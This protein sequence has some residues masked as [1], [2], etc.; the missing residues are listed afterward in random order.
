MD[1]LNKP[2]I[3]LSHATKDK[4]FVER[5]ASDLRKC[6]VEPWLDSEE[7]RDGRPWL[8]MIFEDGIATCDCILVYLTENSINSKMVQK[9][10]DA[11][12][13]QQLDDEGVTFLPYVSIQKIR[14]KL[15]TDIRSLHCREWNSKNYYKV[16]PSVVAEIWQSYLERTVR[17]AI[18]KERVEKQE[19]EK[20]YIELKNRTKATPFSKAQIQDFQYIYDALNLKVQYSVSA[21]IH[22]GTIS[23]RNSIESAFEYD[24]SVDFLPIL[25]GYVKSGHSNYS[26]ERFGNFLGKLSRDKFKSELPDN[27]TLHATQPQPN[28]STELLTLGLMKTSSN[29]YGNPFN[30][31]IYKFIY[32]LGYNKLLS[33]DVKMKIISKKKNT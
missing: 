6:K 30:A 26:E 25:I 22:E 12:F 31:K 1:R 23:F 24:V 19:I 15:R 11:A 4:P 7:I 9:E 27:A 29:Y 2:R 33:E 10:I 5:I 8:K 21:I 3:F 28:L 16:L 17:Q 18:L 32:W 14:N 20:K 13:I